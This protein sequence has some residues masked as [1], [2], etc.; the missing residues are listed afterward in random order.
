LT[1]ECR[2]G[3][4]GRNETRLMRSWVSRMRLWR[5]CAA[6]DARRS[7]AGDEAARSGGR[8]NPRGL[9]MVYASTS[10]ALA[11]LE[12][13]ANAEDGVPARQA[14]VE[15]D[16]PRGVSCDT[17]ASSRLPERW[18]AVRPPAACRE[19]GR[20]WVDRARSA[21]LLVPSA[22]V[23]HEH[24]VLVNPAHPHARRLRIVRVDPLRID[25]RLRR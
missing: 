20:A 24:N 14:V 25:P 19:L 17:L 12:V 15:I 5:I 18:C 3:A 1:Q 8:W 21:V 7:L 4:Q 10:R 11:L 9:P 23:P 13:L 2:G 6:K 16:V 22:L